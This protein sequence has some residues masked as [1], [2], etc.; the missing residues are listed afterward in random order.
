MTQSYWPIDPEVQ[1]TIDFVIMGLCQKSILVPTDSTSCQFVA[2]ECISK[3][4][5]SRI[6]GMGS[7]RIGTSIFAGQ[8]LSRTMVFPWLFR[9]HF[10]I[11]FP[12][13]DQSRD[14]VPWI[15]SCAALASFSGTSRDRGAEEAEWRL[16]VPWRIGACS[17][18]HLA[19]MRVWDGLRENWVPPN[20]RWIIATTRGKVG[21]FGSLFTQRG[22]R[23]ALTR[24]SGVCRI[25]T[26]S[27]VAPGAVLTPFASEK[28]CPRPCL[29]DLGV[30][31]EKPENG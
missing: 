31:P 25:A 29:L 14:R 30:V 15:M 20:S 7:L 6:P 3:S 21:Q 24:T 10:S 12:T 2:P 1:D 11:F 22:R 17:R 18:R 13:V 5:W 9:C 4:G 16:L 27:P 8:E 28:R 23:P 19:N 26:G